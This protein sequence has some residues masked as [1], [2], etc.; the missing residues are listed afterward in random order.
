[1]GK[2][3]CDPGELIEG[4]LRIFHNF[5]GEDG[6]A[7]EIG[8]I[9]EAV[10]TTSPFAMPCFRFGVRY[11]AESHSW[12]GVPFDEIPAQLGGRLPRRVEAFK[13]FASV[14]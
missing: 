3:G 1:M 4:G 5:G 2:I 6:R 11:F 14:V 9:A 8:G 7:G 13:D 10:T 12:L